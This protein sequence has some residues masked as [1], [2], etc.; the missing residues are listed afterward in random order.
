MPKLPT[1]ADLGTARAQPDSSVASIQLSPAVDSTGPAR[2]MA[3]LGADVQQMAAQEQDKLDSLRVEA[4]TTKLRQQELD[5]TIGKTGYQNLHGGDVVNQPVLDNYTA[6]YKQA[7]EGIAQGLTANQQAKFNALAQRGLS[8][9]QAGVMQHSLN[10]T[11]K[12]DG[13]V[14]TAAKQ[15]EIDSA[16]KQADNPAAI[17]QSL[18]NVDALLATRVNN[19]GIRD[20]NLLDALVK[21]NHG[22]VHAAVINTRIQAGD[23]SG[24]QQYLTDNKADMPRDV[25]KGIERQMKPLNDDALGTDIAVEVFKKTQ[26]KSMS[27]VDAALYIAEKT[28]GNPGANNA[29][30]AE[31]NRLHAADTAQDE[32][33][34]GAL[35]LKYLQS[36][37]AA[38]ASA[39]RKQALLDTT[40][41]DTQ[42]AAV[43]K[44][45]DDL[46][47]QD[48]A[49][50]RAATNFAW[51]QQEHNMRLT[52]MRDDTNA[53]K[54]ST[55]V[56][57]GEILS[58]PTLYQ[59]SDAQIA[60]Y[61]NEIG[62]ANTKTLMQAV[63]SR[64][65]QAA[66]FNIDQTLLN[67]AATSAAGD[68]K[69]DASARLA[70]KAIVESNLQ[71]WQANNPGKIPSQLEQTQLLRSGL[72][73]YRDFSKST[74]FGL[75]SGAVP[76][77]K[78]TPGRS[79]PL[80]FYSGAEAY[81]KKQG[82]PVTEDKILQMYQSYKGGLK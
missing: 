20:P 62:I 67:D 24:A 39:I 57:T 10:E 4:A 55:F 46:R 33:A 13:E 49:Q 29:A 43:L 56:R 54:L 2:A 71:Q 59:K 9:F 27:P 72:S 19:L 80:D 37:S 48:I 64:K 15:T 60:S 3:S 47:Q 35:I 34:R 38:T 58:D 12:Y 76:A 40:L 6:Q 69:N 74:Y 50:G 32:E 36:P 5:L 70:Y 51:S 22:Q 45:V 68:N 1:I 79:V 44:T 14:F 66:K 77:Y 81:L 65:D 53:N 31:L 30:M 42:K 17:A 26:D 21:E 7:T 41:S 52:A 28:K 63:H 61:A 23:L 11:N 25:V 78:A 16:A 75:S 73:Q 18:S 82:K 8:Q